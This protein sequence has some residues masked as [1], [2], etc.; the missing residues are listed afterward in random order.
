MAIREIGASVTLDATTFKKEMS[1]VNTNLAGLQAEMKAVT[2]EFQDQAG[3]AEALA[4]RQRVLGEIEAQQQEKVAALTKAYEEQKDATGENSVEADN[5]RKQLMNARAA[6]ANTQSQAKKNAE[7][8]KQAAAATKEDASAQKELADKAKE[9]ATGIGK[10]TEKLKDYAKE[11]EEAKKNSLSGQLKELGA[12]FKEAAE[13]VP[14]LGSA[15]KAVEKSGAVA[16]KGLQLTAKATGAIITGAAAAAAALGTLAVAGLK[17]LT[18]YAVEAARAVD[19]DGNLINTQFSTLAENLTRLD[20]GASAAKTALGTILLP[21][22]ESLSGAGAELLQGF[23][24]D[25][26][27]ASGDTEA[28]GKVCSKYLKEAAKVI[29]Q[30]MP[31]LISLGKEILT[32]LLEGISDAAPELLSIAGDLIRM[33]LDGISENANSMGEGAAQIVTQLLT[34]ILEHAPDLLVAGIQLLTSL[35]TG[36]TSNLPQL[37]PVAIQAVQQLLQALVENAPDL[38]VGGATLILTLVEGLIDH[39]PDLIAAIPQLISDFVNG[40]SSSPALSD[41]TDIG[42]RIV[43]K[44]LE[45][46]KA[47]WNAVKEWFQGAAG[48]L[49]DLLGGGG[50]SG[51]A[52]GLNYVPY[53]NYPA[54]LHRGERVL[55][56]AEAASGA[57]GGGGNRTVN[58]TINA[59]SLDRAQADYWIR[60]ADE[61]LGKDV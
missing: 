45:G 37:I 12:A 1:A 23:S 49:G 52:G 4:E 2:A 26:A 51:H 21:A 33:L 15:L 40:F 7:A 44:I 57:Y 48:T 3:S 19:A 13:S 30:E 35:M 38:L 17:T 53:D 36:I 55:T 22:L 6:L 25:L 28:M 11:Q 58:L 60:R 42:S 34:F 27:A 50:G 46:L 61:E 32:A 56:A 24:A 18:D 9:G 39:I 16:E 5:L 14:V 8:Q 29:K 41:L 10:L 31:E 47:A 54:I 20:A 59:Q 43:D